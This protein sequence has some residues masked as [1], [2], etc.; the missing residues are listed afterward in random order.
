MAC[1]KVQE[2]LNALLDRELPVLDWVKVRAHLLVCRT[3]RQ[4]LNDYRR[5]SLAAS[6][7]RTVP[8]PHRARLVPAAALA[9]VVIAVFA[10]HTSPKARTPQALVFDEASLVGNLKPTSA[11]YT[12]GDHLVICDPGSGKILASAPGKTRKDAFNAISLAYRVPL[13]E[14]KAFK[15]EFKPSKEQADIVILENAEFIR[16]EG[17]PNIIFFSGDFVELKSLPLPKGGPTF[18][19]KVIDPNFCID[20][21]ADTSKSKFVPLPNNKPSSGNR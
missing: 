12:E 4:R 2:M 19:V 8:K 16:K 14:P 18:F 11:I 3:C 6:F 5:I 1:E 15:V 17:E 21:Q 10:L 13:G 20:L 9:L 7:V